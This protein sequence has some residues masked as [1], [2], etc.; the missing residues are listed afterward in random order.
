MKKF[1]VAFI[2]A[3][4]IGAF[5]AFD[6]QQYLSF[7]FFQNLYQ[8]NQQEA[9]IIFFAV[10]VFSTALS[11]PG[12]AILT[13]I[14]GALFGLQTGVI[15]VSFASTIGATLAFL[16]S[17]TLLRDWVQKKFGS[18][19]KTIN[20]GIEREGSFYLFT[21]R[22]IP[23]IPFFVV[24]LV[25]GLTPIRTLTFFFISQLG[26]LAGTIV[27]VNAGAELGKVDSLSFEGILTPGLIFSFIALAVF[28]W[29]AKAMIKRVRLF[30]LY[31]DYVKPKEFDRNMIVI[32]AGSGGLIAALIA[33]VTKAKVTLIEKHKMGGDC[34]NTGCVPSKA[35]IRSAK[36]KKYM[37]NAKDYGLEAV[38]TSTQF[39]E[40][41]ARVQK[42]IKTIEPHDSVE[43]FTSLGVECIQGE[44]RIINPYHVE[45]NGQTFSTQNIVI[46]TGGSPRVPDIE[47]VKEVS[48]YTS[49]TFWSMETLPKRFL[50]IGGGP[51]GCELAQAMSRLG[52]EVTIITRGD[53]L[54]P[55]ED[56]DAAE[57]VEKRFLQEGIV[58]YKHGHLEKFEKTEAGVSRVIFHQC[59]DDK[60]TLEFDVVLFAAGRQAN[61]QG[62][63]LEQLNMAFDPDGTLN[64]NEYMQTKYPNIYAC[65]DVTGPFQLTHAASHQAWY[66]AVNALFGRFKKF[67]ADYSVLPWATFTDPEV[68]RV[69]LSEAE[70]KAQNIEYEV[71][72]Y[73]IDDLDRAIADSEAHGFIK[74]LT[75]P[76]KD[77]ILGVT[78]VGFHAGDI[79]AEYVLAMRHGLGLNKIMG[80]VHI[81]PTLTESNKFVAGV[82]KK[83]RAPQGLLRWVEKYHHRKLKKS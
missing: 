80:T 34:L 59:N 79:I 28:P 66:C 13:L 70:A 46:A 14:A 18:Y 63:G 39:S 25:M 9:L 33:A 69:G 64:V 16:I 10:Y 15:L 41:M 12:A 21:I 27:Y 35:I 24:N 56:A 78:I 58:L 55:K 71:T 49:D 65:G 44:A 45:V 19:L 75:V 74:V 51:I 81:Y 43:R 83:E 17:R 1:I 22:L 68:A 37:D 62:F 7:E 67:K 5:F 32:G 48:Y 23:F 8:N 60:I 6:G 57:V 26:M 50:V 42:I 29:V 36:I 53:R 72:R 2:V 3:G 73:D 47:G 82:W 11:L 54:L 40:V 61:T 30:L 76:G 38:H 4:L 31:R 20:Q 77:K 52:S